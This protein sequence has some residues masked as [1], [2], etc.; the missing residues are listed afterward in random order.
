MLISDN[1]TNIFA[2]LFYKTKEHILRKKF[3][4]FKKTNYLWGEVDIK[5][6]GSHHFSDDAVSS[7]IMNTNLK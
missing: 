2:K 3:D 7:G 5:A 4:G 1:V 6:L